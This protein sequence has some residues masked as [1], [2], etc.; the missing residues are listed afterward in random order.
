MPQS[1]SR[2]QISSLTEDI[3]PGNIETVKKIIIIG[4]SGHA[5]EINEYMTVI[6]RE[7]GQHNQ[8]IVG[9]IDDDPLNYDKYRFTA[10]YLGSIRDHEVQKSHSYIIAI[11]NMDYRRFIVE[12]FLESEAG[13]ITLIHPTAYVSESA[14]IGIGTVL[15]PYVNVGPN[16]KIG[17]FNL[18]NSRASLGHDTVIGDYNII[19]P[20]VSLSGFTEIGDE[21]LFGINSATKPGIK[22]GH[23]NRVEAG[24]VLDKSISSHSTIFFRYKEKVI[25]IPKK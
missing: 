15:G 3:Q 21:N 23:R 18:I 10:P 14:K 6:N 5:A 25:A 8:C 20:N 2:D 24:M 9:F 17:S 12:K 19:S 11:A 16:V 1:G 4:A 22:V 7:S 13:F